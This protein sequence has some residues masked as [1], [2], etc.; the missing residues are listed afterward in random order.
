MMAGVNSRTGNHAVTL[1]AHRR[2][3]LLVARVV[4]GAVGRFRPKAFIP[5]AEKEAVL[6]EAV[7]QAL[8]EGEEEKAFR[9]EGVMSKKFSI[10]LVGVSVLMVF[11]F[12]ARICGLIWIPEYE[13]DLAYH[14][15]V[16]LTS[17]ITIRGT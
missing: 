16:S 3:F 12:T 4:D 10:L 1:D 14:I 8:W 11:M 6:K 15:D 17:Q 13:E 5:A 7:P 9:R 2:D